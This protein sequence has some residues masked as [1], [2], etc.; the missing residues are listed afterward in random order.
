MTCPPSL[1]G[2]AF[3]P[4]TRPQDD[5]WGHVNNRWLATDPIPADRARWGLSDMRRAQVADQL[6]DLL[7]A[8]ASGA[9]D[10]SAEATALGALYAAFLDGSRREQLAGSALAPE[11]AVIATAADTAGILRAVGRLMRGGI[12]SFFSWWVLPLSLIHI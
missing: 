6:V 8:C 10:G 1:A 3:A 11:M 4:G 2:T 7:T 9:V 12:P 5:L